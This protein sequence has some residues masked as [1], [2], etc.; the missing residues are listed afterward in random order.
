LN[1]SL[2]EDAYPLELAD[3]AMALGDGDVS[4]TRCTIL[5]RMSV[6]RLEASECILNDLA[7]VDDTQHGC[8]RFCCWAANSVLPRQYESVRTA[9]GANLFTSTAFGQP[10]YCQ[11]LP[12]ADSQITGGS[13]S[14]VSSAP[15]GILSGAQS[16]SEMGA[17]CLQQNSIKAQALLIKYQ[18]YMPFGLAPVL[19]YVT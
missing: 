8:V 5:D 15:P 16:G 11:L 2:L 3:A 19:I 13:G 1:R 4:L 17:F 10:G 12:T 9:A 6:H 14:S 18:E 7:V